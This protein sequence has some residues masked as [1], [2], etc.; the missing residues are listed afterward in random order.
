MIRGSDTVKLL[1]EYGEG[2][3]L[4]YE[5][6]VGLGAEVSQLL[7]LQVKDVKGKEYLSLPVGPRRCR[8]TFVLPKS[9]CERIDSYILGRE[10][11]LFVDDEGSPVT[12]ERARKVLLACGVTGSF[13]SITM[14]RYYQ[15]TNDIHYPMFFMDLPTKEATM[16][17]IC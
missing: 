2:Y 3:A 10:K 17:A 12:E 16:E 9:L 13:L 4:L 1:S 8:R 7:E 14:G 11:M 15:E 6:G 5:I